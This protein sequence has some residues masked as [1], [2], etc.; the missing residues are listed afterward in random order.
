[1]S[2]L[3]GS[4]KSTVAYQK[5]ESLDLRSTEA[6]KEIRLKELTAFT[7]LWSEQVEGIKANINDNLS[8]IDKIN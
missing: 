4:K 1:M 7:L 8:R 5:Q 2:I 3:Q 6:G